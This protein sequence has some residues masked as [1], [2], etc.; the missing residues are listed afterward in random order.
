MTNNDL[1]APRFSKKN[2]KYD[3]IS[4]ELYLKWVKEYPEK[5]V[6][7]Q[8]FLRIWKFITNEITN[9]MATNP[10]GIKLPYYCGDFVVQYLPKEAKITNVESLKEEER[11]N[12]LNIVSKGK[13]AK[14]SWIRRVASKFN[15][16]MI[17]FG[18]DPNKRVSQLVQNQIYTN[19]SIYRN[20]RMKYSKKN[21]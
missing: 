4:K 19:P 21:D 3:L 2:F 8:E 13:T 12:Y 11:S 9:T 1:N 18:F 7:F 14:I 17:Y 6:T 15:P 10:M 5:Y 20:T 16:S